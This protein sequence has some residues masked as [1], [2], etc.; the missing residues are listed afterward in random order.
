MEWRTE[1]FRISDVTAELDIQVV[2]DLLQTTYWAQGRSRE[3]IERSIAASLCFALFNGGGEQIGFL[4]VVTDRATFAWV[5][6]VVVAGEFRGRGLGKWLVA[7]MLEH[8]ALAETTKYLGTKDAHGLYE[9]YGFI[10]REILRR[11]AA[12]AGS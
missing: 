5:C 8:P 6:D 9:Q 12:P 11:E 2:Y 1:G 4:R 10:R 7:C 3:R